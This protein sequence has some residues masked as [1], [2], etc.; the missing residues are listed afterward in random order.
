M[1]MTDKETETDKEN[2]CHIQV[3]VHIYIHINDTVPDLHIVIIINQDSMKVKQN[4]I[5]RDIKIKKTETETETIRISPRII[6]HT[7]PVKTV[8]PTIIVEADMIISMM[9]MLQTVIIMH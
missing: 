3:H 9:K 2:V 8:I 5:M 7:I 1:K 4:G 6:I